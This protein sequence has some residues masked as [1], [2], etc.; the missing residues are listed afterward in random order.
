MLKQITILI[1]ISISTNSCQ[2]QLSS[3]ICLPGDIL[4]YY[5]PNSVPAGTGGA[6]SQS[7]TDLSLSW[8]H[9]WQTALS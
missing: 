3:P 9:N 2:V 6:I 7:N 5:F 1:N 8:A 4:S